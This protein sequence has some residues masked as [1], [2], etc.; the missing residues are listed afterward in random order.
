MRV[1][2]SGLQQG[3]QLL[4]GDGLAAQVLR[5]DRPPGPDQEAAGGG[6]GKFSW[7]GLPLF[8]LRREDEIVKEEEQCQG[9]SKIGQTRRHQKFHPGGRLGQRLQ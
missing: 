1:E 9:R 7:L 5:H 4:P 3:L 2:K 6:G 8:L